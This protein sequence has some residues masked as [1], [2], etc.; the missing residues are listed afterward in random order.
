MCRPN[1]EGLTEVRNAGGGGVRERVAPFRWGVARGVTTEI[2]FE[3]L[4]LICITLS[5][6]IILIHIK[7]CITFQ[8]FVIVKSSESL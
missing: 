1:D 8:R 5:I 6:K 3:L 7:Y 2:C 4:G